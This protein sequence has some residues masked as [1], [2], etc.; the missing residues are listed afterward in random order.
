MLYDY[1]KKNNHNVFFCFT[2]NAYKIHD[3]KSLNLDVKNKI[4][5]NNYIKLPDPDFI[6]FYPLTVNTLM[7]INYN[8][9]DNLP[10]TIYFMCKKN[11]LLFLSSSKR[12]INDKTKTVIN[13]VSNY[14]NLFVNKDLKDIFKL[15]DKHVKHI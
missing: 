10:L 5:W 14:E 9:I 3:F 6:I 7:K 2:E 15:I 13:K 11:K 4:T 12:L 8:I 1:L